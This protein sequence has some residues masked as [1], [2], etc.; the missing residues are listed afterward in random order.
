MPEPQETM[1]SIALPVYNRTTYIRQAL[2]S[3]LHQNYSNFEII[4]IDD[5]PHD[6][7]RSIIESYPSSKIR[8]IKKYTHIGL[9]AKLNESLQIAKGRWMVVLC[10]DDLLTPDY[11]STLMGHIEKY[12]EVKLFRCRYQMI[13]SK[14]DALW[15]DPPCEFKMGSFEFLSKIFLPESQFFKMYISGIL[16]P[17]VLLKSLGGFKNFHRAWNTDRLA[18]AELASLGGCV[19]EPRTLC[20]IRLHT[21]AV[22]GSVDPR[23]DLTIES[24][25]GMQKAATT[26]LD[27]MEKKAVSQ[28]EKE[29]LQSARH[30]LKNHIRGNF[31]R[32]IDQGLMHTLLTEK[33]HALNALKQVLKKSWKLNVPQSASIR[34]Y[35]AIAFLPYELRKPIAQRLQQ[36]KFHKWQGRGAAKPATHVA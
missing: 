24:T 11:L 7:N 13:D 16:F 19:C 2:E 17:T 32:A 9:S 27:Q 25:F 14:A 33:H 12:P 29:K 3:C 35:L 28:D 18:W 36:Y 15:L 8:Y 23:Y 5:S 21:A 4:L 20:S 34:L 10:D 30:L 22:T 1:V 31:A 26:L 6:E